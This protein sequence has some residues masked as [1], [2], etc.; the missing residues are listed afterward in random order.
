[1]HQGRI[2]DIKIEDEMASSYIDYSMSVIIGRALPDVRDGLKP[3]HRRI[4]FGM[5]E[6]GLAPNRPYKKSARVV[7]DVLG[8]YHPHGDSAVYD[9]MVRMVQAFSLRY[10]LISGQ[11]NFGSVDGDAA[12]AMRYTE[13]RLAPLADQLL[14]D[15][16]K[17]TV[18]FVP[19]FDESLEEPSV[20]PSTLPNLLINGSSGIAV[21]MAT[22]IPPH[23]LQEVSDAIIA[24]IDNP[25]LDVTELMTYVQ[26]PDFP[27]G[28]I[29]YGRRGIYDA[30][31][32]G[33]GRI[34]VRGKADI[35]ENHK[36]GRER[37]IVTEIPFMVN[38]STLIEKIAQLVRDKKIEGI[39]D[40]RDESDR[41]GM[42]I[43]IELKK[44]AFGQV[45]L[46]HL[47]QHTQLQTTFGA[48]VLALD[49]KQPKLMTLRDLIDHYIAFRREVVTRRTQF[50]LRKAKSREHILEGLSTAIDNID[51]VI[52]VIRAS[53]DPDKARATLMARFDLSE[54]QAKAI[55]EMR[56]QR[57]TGLER[58]K[59]ETELAE[60]RD[61]IADLES[62][63]ASAARISDIIK[64]EL[65][66]V[67]E[68]FGD[69]RRTEIVD[70]SGDFDIEDLIAEEDMVITVSHRGYVK[71][72]PTS[73]YRSQQRGGRGLTGVSTR[74]EDFPEHIFVA[75][76]HSYILFFTSKGSCHWLK[77]HQIPQAGRI[78]KGKAIVNLI[79][80][81]KGEQIRAYVPVREFDPNQYIVF[82]TSRGVV[83]KTKLSDFSRPRRA[84]IRAINILDDDALIGASLCEANDELM[85]ATRK[86][87]SIRFSESDVRSMGRVS[88]GVRGIRLRD[89]DSVVSLLKLGN[90]VDI[91]TVCERGY[92]KKT[93]EGDYRIQTRGGY[94]IRNILC[95]ERNGD[96]VAVKAVTESDEVILMSREGVI[97]RLR[98]DSMRA[99][100]RSTQGVR[101]IGLRGEDQVVD[102]SKVASS[103]VEEGSFD[104]ELLDSESRE[105][106]Q[107]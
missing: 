49:N 107:E 1:M 90:D 62:I 10:P 13:A 91:L 50:Q 63:L 80:I 29:I 5:R 11:G 103:V 6:L 88:T 93:P 9:A 67:S 15:I 89:D 16:E 55:L 60:I 22:N 53:A 8:K 101:F 61:L 73:A 41:S 51:A 45:I 33:R 32:T 99:I 95:S 75:S 68:R 12:A 72:I 57:L 94:G 27:T 58:E 105:K 104:E 78:A 71:R 69:A 35:E 76:T 30:Y 102:V 20:L 106:S 14:N 7:G 97:I 79:S 4:L 37:I 47:Y 44:D 40:I 85:L 25:D 19:N 59:I 21:G 26:G 52:E 38:K 36:T 2:V 42:R 96:V 48:N 34:I 64:S 70:A 43:V 83:K 46:N 100:R 54:T 3:V 31:T 74:E 84:G 98:V 65:K 92:G 24:V 87:Q 23:N 86:G 18:D 17:E 28:G 39:S 77:V 66:A 82:C 81:D 56:L